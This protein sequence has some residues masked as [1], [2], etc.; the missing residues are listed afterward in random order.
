MAPFAKQIR[1]RVFGISPEEVTFARRGFRPGERSR[2]ERLERIGHDFLSGY[3][4][5]IAEDDLA[6]LE[7]V[8]LGQPREAHGFAYE[9]AA[10]GLALLDAMS[11]RQGSR[12]DRFLAGIG[13]PHVYTAHVG[14]GWAHARLPG[15][16]RRRVHPEDPL[17]R[18]LVLDGIGFHDGYFHAE[19]S[20]ARR[21]VP[22][23]LTG[24]ERRAFDQGLG[25]VLWFHD[26][27]DSDR[28]PATILSF[29]ENRHPDLW[30][31]VGLACAY[32]GGASRSE[33]RE[34]AAAAGANH[35]HFAQG[36]A[37]AAK[38]HERAGVAPEHTVVACAEGCGVTIGEAAAM[39]DEGQENLP[40]EDGDAFPAYEVWRSRVRTALAAVAG[41]DARTSLRAGS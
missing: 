13:A 20:F 35:L 41:K 15:F 33:V 18:W 30:S 24:Y 36:I 1:R 10:M 37:F 38:A 16:L 3:H 32:A 14:V 27:A 26:C 5:A 22:P 40:T 23:R 31:G 34:L 4:A 21:V 11:P 6:G 12:V 2:Q 17:L 39:C 25:R 29:G 8:L 19:R 28:V 7:R 9:G